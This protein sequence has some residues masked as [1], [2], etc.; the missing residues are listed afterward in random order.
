MRLDEIKAIPILEVAERLGIAVKG[1]SAH[2]FSHSPDRHPSLVFNPIK[3]KFRCYV[4]PDIHG[5]VIDLVMQVR[6]CSF[7]EAINELNPDRF[8]HNN[9]HNHR[10]PAPKWRKKNHSVSS[11]GI[12]LNYK[13]TLFN[14]LLS[15]APM[16]QEGCR[17]IKARGIDIA[18]AESMGVG[19]LR[20][21]AFCSLYKVMIDL[22]GRKALKQCGLS[23]FFLLANEGLSFLL[24]PY[25]HHGRIHLIK[26]RCLLTKTEADQREIKRFVA[27][28]E[29]DI[30]YNQDTIPISTTVYLCEGEFD[31]LTL[32][33]RG[34]SAIGIPG[35]SSFRKEWFEWLMDKHVVLCLDRDAGSE[36]AIAWF[37]EACEARGIPY[38]HF[39]LPEGMDINE[40]FYEMEACVGYAQS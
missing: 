34:Y 27:T 40:Y 32:L 28:Q 6:N 24:F 22:Y 17:Y 10:L 9:H 20:P 5:S 35:V 19:F 8:T 16:A 33:Q 2:C 3:N 13:D 4:C 36:L 39:D 1:R 25:R 21:E 31:T 38:S 12:S 29:A 23:H 7:K 18:T 30:F 11:P 14:T 37:Q 26:A 15:V